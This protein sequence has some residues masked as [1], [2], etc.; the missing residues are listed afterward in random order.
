MTKIMQC[1]LGSGV[2][3]HDNVI[4]IIH[5]QVHEERVLYCRNCK[6]IAMYALPIDYPLVDL[7]CDI[8]TNIGFLT[9]VIPK[10]FL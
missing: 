3:M 6:E 4:N 5:F 7:E 10:R 9:R 2:R 1:G 8:C